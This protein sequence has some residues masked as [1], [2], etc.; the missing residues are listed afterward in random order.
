L[1]FI[2]EGRA[3]NHYLNMRV[4]VI[5]NVAFSCDSTG[6]FVALA[7]KTHF[8]RLTLFISVLPYVIIL[9]IGLFVWSVLSAATGFAR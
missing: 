7:A 4:E 5:D 8:G 2:Q 3:V 1:T 9:F 6:I